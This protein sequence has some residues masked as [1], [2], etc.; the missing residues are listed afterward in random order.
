M[1]KLLFIA[2]MALTA[3]VGKAQDVEQG[4]RM[5]AQVNV[6][7]SNVIYDGDKVSFGY[8]I[9]WVAE[10]NFSPNLYLQS[11]VGLQSISH[12]ENAI[13][14]TISAFYAQVPIHVGY[15]FGINDNYSLFVQAGPT[16]GIGLWGSSIEYYGGGSDNYFDLAK[17]FDLGVGGRVGL[18]FEKFKVSLGVDYGVLEVFD[19]GGHNLSANVGFAYMF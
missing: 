6:G 12:K 11:G 16:L 2:M 17:R 4:F 5:G 8:G 19:A 10:Y 18:E 14:G 15:R 9:G 3:I 1:K 7:L 13:D